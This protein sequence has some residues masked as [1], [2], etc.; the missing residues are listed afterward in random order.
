MLQTLS[1]R[2]PLEDECMCQPHTEC[3]LTLPTGTRWKQFCPRPPCRVRKSK[4]LSGLSARLMSLWSSSKVPALPSSVCWVAFR[5]WVVGRNS[6]LK[7]YKEH[8]GNLV[9]MLERPGSGVRH[10]SVLRWTPHIKFPGV[11]WALPD[12]AFFQGLTSLA[13]A[14][15]CWCQMFHRNA[16]VDRWFMRSSGVGRYRT[17]LGAAGPWG[18]EPGRSRRRELGGRAT[19]GSRSA[20]E[21]RRSGAR[22]RPGRLQ[23]PSCVFPQGTLSAQRGQRSGAAATCGPGPAER[24]PPPGACR[25]V[26]CRVEPPGPAVTHRPGP[27]HRFPRLDRSHFSCTKLRGDRGGAAGPA[28]R[29]YV[30][31]GEGR[32]GKGRPGGR[33][34]LC[35]SPGC[36]PLLPRR[37]ARAWSSSPQPSGRIGGKRELLAKGSARV[38]LGNHKKY[39]EPRLKVAFRGSSSVSCR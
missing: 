16:F 26:P 33:R 20:H 38:H 8:I 25:A 5:V 15:R 11:L 7:E 23:P 13:G 22:R 18:G 19:R 36:W 14:R 10:V 17:A 31:P 1:L 35:G 32:E 9:G 6:S 37:A 29:R 2:K 24:R 12:F 4:C 39:T 21:A 3:V 28:S 34:G 30:L 27:G